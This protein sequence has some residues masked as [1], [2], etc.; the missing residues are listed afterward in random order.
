MPAGI[1]YPAVGA[2]LVNVQVDS[3][4][5]V[6]PL[7]YAIPSSC[8]PNARKIAGSTVAATLA[9]S[10]AMFASVCS[11]MTARSPSEAFQSG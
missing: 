9:M 5:A 3:T 11:R 1:R 6:D 10:A 4:L 2:G 8:V 7:L